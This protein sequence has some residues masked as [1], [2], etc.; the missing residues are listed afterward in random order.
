MAQLVKILPAMQETWVRSL[1]EKV[2]LRRE[3]LPTPVFCPGNSMDCIV[4][5]VA[6][7]WTGT[8]LSDLH[9]HFMANVQCL[10]LARR[11]HLYSASLTKQKWNPVC[12]LTCILTVCSVSPSAGLEI[13]L[14]SPRD[15]LIFFFF[16][17]FI[18]FNWRLITL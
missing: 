17:L 2:P 13:V 11:C 10:F 4:S 16:N 7:N 18:Y 14:K 9:F 3:R 12:I 6:N 1:G 15:C 5:G 8:G